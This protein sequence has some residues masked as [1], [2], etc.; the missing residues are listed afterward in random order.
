MKGDAPARE[1]TMNLVDAIRLSSIL[2]ALV[3]ALLVSAICA[4]TLRAAGIPAVPGREAAALARGHAARNPGHAGPSAKGHRR[5]PRH[6]SIATHAVPPSS[7]SRRFTKG[8]S[9]R[10]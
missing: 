10:S 4:A 1:K 8:T 7:A 6:S 3:A 9:S 2:A 5:P